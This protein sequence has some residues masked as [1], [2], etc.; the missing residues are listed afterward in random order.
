MKNGL[1]RE[2]DE[3]WQDNIL[4]LTLRKRIESAIHERARRE[5]YQWLLEHPR[6]KHMM[7]ETVLQAVLDP[8]TR[9]ILDAAINKPND[10][11]LDNFGKWLAALIKTPVNNANAFTMVDTGGATRTFYAYGTSSG[12]YW[13]FNYSGAYTGTYLQVGKG[14]TA[15]QRSN[16]NI[17]TAMGTAPESTVFGTGNGSYAAGNISFSSAITAG[18]A[19][20]IYETGFF[21]YW[22]DTV[23]TLRTIMLFHDLLQSGVAFTAGKSL[24][25]SYAIAI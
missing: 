12:S 22:Y 4:G 17:Q 24:V 20:T 25:T 3:H 18:G 23:A 13:Y 9:K 21:G 1:I 5:E 11:I 6:A 15:A 16:T 19:D 8:K 10:L 2:N 7:H 14:Q